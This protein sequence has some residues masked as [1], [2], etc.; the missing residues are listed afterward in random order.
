MKPAERLAA[1]PDLPNS[2]C[3]ALFRLI[4][5]SL[6]GWFW[7]GLGSA[8]VALSVVWILKRPPAR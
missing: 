1:A 6:T 8:I 7:L 2:R 5:V 4:A 3:L